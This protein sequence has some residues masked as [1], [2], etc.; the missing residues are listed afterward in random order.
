LGEI[1]LLGKSL[2]F[3][4]FCVKSEISFFFES[5]MLGEFRG[6]LV[7]YEKHFGHTGGRQKMK[8]LR[9]HSQGD[10]IGRTFAYCETF[11]FG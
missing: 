6:I 5:Q 2:F 4:P 3:V 11:F 7:A 8:S 1:W 10:Q 9:R